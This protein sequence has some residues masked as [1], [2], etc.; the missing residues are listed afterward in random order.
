MRIVILG[1]GAVGSLLG[2]RL[3]RAGEEVLLV[4]SPMHVEAI[5]ARG[6]RVE[7]LLEGTFSVRAE[8]RVPPGTSAD[9][10]WLTVKTFDLARAA[11]AAAVELPASIP[12]VLPQN[13]L[14]VETLARTAMQAAGRVA[15]P[16]PWLVRAVNTIP[17]TLVEPGVVRQP[18][19][20]EIRLADPARA[21]TSAPSVRLVA[22]GLER[23]GVPVRFVPDI[24]R[25]QWRKAIVNAAI[26]PITAEYGL[27]NGQLLDDPWRSEATTLLLEA[28][29]AARLA[30]FDFPLKELEHDLWETARATAGNRSS[31]LQDV[32]RGRPTEIASIS[33]YFLDTARAH[34]VELPATEHI[35]ERI[36]HRAASARPPRQ[37][38]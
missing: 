31:M 20:G 37:R 22:A 14:G 28:L 35:V 9:L 34:A 15:S 18:G 33:G 12:W 23:A 36:R 6:L 27:L 24:D 7:G 29:S 3:Q 8:T 10:L 38:S 32:D 2:A 11:E 5:R 21:G 13:G 4:G 1:A 17:A 26:N 25:A 30:G 16:D 19:E